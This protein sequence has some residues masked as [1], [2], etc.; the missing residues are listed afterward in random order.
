MAASS[1]AGA[2]VMLDARQL[3]MFVCLPTTH[4][5]ASTP[6]PQMPLPWQLFELYRFCD[7]QSPERGGIQFLDAARLL[8]LREMLQA[9]QDRHGP[10][11]SARAFAALASCSTDS[12]AAG[13][14]SNRNG[15]ASNSSHEASSSG[16]SDVQH[17]LA[18]PPDEAPA[19][20]LPFTDELRGR[21]RFAMDLHG[22]IW[23]ASGWHTLPVADSLHTLIRRVLT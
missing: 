23:L 22:R 4:T 13:G 3:S 10:L 11:D 1:A 14:G 2:S 15:A 17:P 21:K 7:G 5:P 20:L 6:L 8:S 19:V 18:G 16:S 12:D 9:T